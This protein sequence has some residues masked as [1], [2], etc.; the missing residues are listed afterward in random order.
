[1]QFQTHANARAVLLRTASQGPNGEALDLV[2]AA[3]H[4]FFWGRGIDNS[5]SN[6]LGALLMKV[7]SQLLLVHS[8]DSLVAPMI[9]SIMPGQEPAIVNN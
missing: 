9:T 8:K 2:E 7:R 1:M 6:H 5:G 4:D 3:P